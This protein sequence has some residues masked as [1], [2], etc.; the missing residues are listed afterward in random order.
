MIEIENF[1]NV[2]EIENL[3]FNTFEISRIAP[4]VNYYI[5]LKRNLS[6]PRNARTNI[7]III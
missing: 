4:W 1:K 2:S 3:I 6:V 5:L 7:D